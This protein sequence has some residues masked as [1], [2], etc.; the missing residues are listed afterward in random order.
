MTAQSRVSVGQVIGVSAAGTERKTRIRFGSRLG[1]RG[2]LMCFMK[3]TEFPLT[4]SCLYLSRNCISFEIVL[5]KSSFYYE[6][7]VI[8]N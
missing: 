2:E 1:E 8:C 6:F 7:K 3:N 4:Q 5:V